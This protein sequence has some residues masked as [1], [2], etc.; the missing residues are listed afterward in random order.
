MTQVNLSV[1]WTVAVPPMVEWRRHRENFLVVG[2]EVDKLNRRYLVSC[3][4]WPCLNE[5]PPAMGMECV[6]EVG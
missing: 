6:D 4:Q 2:E 1:R 5:W 3:C